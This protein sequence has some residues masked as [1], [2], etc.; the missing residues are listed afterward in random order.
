VANSHQ[1]RLIC[2]P[3]RIFSLE[4][5]IMSGCGTWTKK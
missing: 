4:S 5:D 1:N 2:W 3:V